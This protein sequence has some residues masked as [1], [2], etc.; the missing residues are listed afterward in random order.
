MTTLVEHRVHILVQTD[1]TLVIIGRA[2]CHARC[3][4][5]STCNIQ[6]VEYTGKVEDI[7]PMAGD[8]GQFSLLEYPTVVYAIQIS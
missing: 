5:T 1:Q 8:A 6:T 3:R 4:G 7:Y 2:R